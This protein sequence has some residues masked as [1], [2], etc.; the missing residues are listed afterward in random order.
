M[1]AQHRSCA[2]DERGGRSYGSGSVRD[3]PACSAFSCLS[4]IIVVGAEQQSRH[5]GFRRTAIAVL[6]CV[7]PCGAQA[8]RH[9]GAAALVMTVPR[10]FRPLRTAIISI[11]ACSPTCEPSKRHSSTSQS[12]TVRAWRARHAN[13]RAARPSSPPPTWNAAP[14]ACTAVCT[15]REPAVRSSAIG[16]RALVGTKSALHRPDPWVQG[17]GVH[18]HAYARATTLRSGLP[19]AS[20]RLRTRVARSKRALAAAAPQA[21]LWAP[22]ALVWRG[23]HPFAM[24]ARVPRVAK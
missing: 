13:V 5:Q 19:A 20:A 7:A 8:V 21:P 14:L 15:L 22:S 17:T 23:T 10:T 6:P 24:P 11:F 1:G 16:R 12:K 2:S 4:K 18:A 3:A 9:D